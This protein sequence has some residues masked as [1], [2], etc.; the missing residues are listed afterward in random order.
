GDADPARRRRDA[1]GDRVGG[2]HGGDVVEGDRDSV[3]AEEDGDDREPGQI[4]AELGQDELGERAAAAAQDR[5]AGRDLGPQLLPPPPE[6]P[7]QQRQQDDRA[8]ED[9]DDQGGVVFE[10][11]QLDPEGALDREEEIEVERDVEDREGD[12]LHDQGGEDEGEG[13]GGEEGG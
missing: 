2:R 3:G 4:A 9:E 5:A 12:L 1:V 8:E 6:D 11:A 7:R 13:G 10:Q